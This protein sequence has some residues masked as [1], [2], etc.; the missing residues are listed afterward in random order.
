[1][2]FSFIFSYGNTY[3]VIGTCIRYHLKKLITMNSSLSE[4]SV[5]T[6][7]VIAHCKERNSRKS[8]KR[9]RGLNVSLSVLNVL[10]LPLIITFNRI[11]Y[12]IQSGWRALVLWRHPLSSFAFIPTIWECRKTFKNSDITIFKKIISADI[13]D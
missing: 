6:Q 3:C 1:M 4:L 9:R 2:S 5:Q 7:E 10:M 8:R 12:K 13:S 11:Q